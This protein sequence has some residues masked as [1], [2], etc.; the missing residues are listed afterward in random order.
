MK[1]GQI[2]DPGFSLSLSFNQG[3]EKDFKICKLSFSGRGGGGGGT[4]Q[5]LRFSPSFDSVRV[6][7]FFIQL[8]IEVLYF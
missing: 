7:D 1:L 5:H 3:Q 8:P 4:W 2:E 6:Q